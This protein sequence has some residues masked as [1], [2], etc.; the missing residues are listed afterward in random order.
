MARS[1]KDVRLDN[2]TARLN[3]LEKGRR[4]Q[5]TLRDGLALCYRRTSQGFGIWSARIED[6][7]G[8]EELRRIGPADD[9]TD[10]DG[11]TSFT[12]VQAQDVARE[13]AQ[14]R[15]AP[16]YTVK[17]ACTDYVTW[18]RDNR[19]SIDATEAT[20]KA[21]ILSALADRTIAS[22]TAEDIKKWRDNLA[23]AHAR[24][25]TRRGR[26]Q[27]HK[28]HDD[29]E[30][31]P[32]Q[33]DEAKRARRATANRI[34]AVLR[35]I[36]N[37]AFQDGKAR[38]DS[39]WRRVKP[40]QKVDV[41]RIRFLTQDEAVRLVNACS[42]EF[43]PLLRA[44]L[45]TGA[46]YGE[47]VRMKVGDFNPTTLQIFVAPSKS[48]KSR[49][50]P[51]NVAGVALFTMLTTGRAA[52][53]PMFARADGEQW[54]KNHQQRPLSE[55]CKRAKITPPLRFHEA[56]HSYASALAQAG[57][58]LLTISKLLGHA[59]TR[60]TSRHYAHLCD[61]TLA[62]AVNNLLPDFGAV[63]QSNVSAIR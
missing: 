48:G 22:L 53:E 51:L 57:A 56:R 44:A 32:D 63:E 26:E 42:M 49:Y 37:K 15:P 7:D 1:A 52:D 54:G 50:I 12:Y 18:F 34:L 9:H 23:Q 8:R 33:R 39:E 17:D 2:R 21:H 30:L 35:A 11:V 4:Y 14:H 16:A 45:L 19:K 13:M 3:R 20:I 10:A 31:T 55:A 25:R 46:R 28:R 40:F 5:V 62:N 38:D 59:D 6:A 27:Q 36:L 29:D 41:P 24:K 58:D 60:V 47:L 61:K 43:R